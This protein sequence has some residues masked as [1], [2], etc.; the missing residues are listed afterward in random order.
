M[1]ELGLLLAGL[2]VGWLAGWFVGRKLQANEY[3]H[4]FAALTKTNCALLDD[5]RAEYEA[6]QRG[7]VA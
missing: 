7:Q 4:Y 3:D 5:L 2:L 1:L 6:D